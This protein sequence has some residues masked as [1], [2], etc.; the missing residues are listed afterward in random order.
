MQKELERYDAPPEA[1]EAKMKVKRCVDE[2]LFQLDKVLI[3]GAVV[4]CLSF[5]QPKIPT[6]RLAWY[7]AEHQGM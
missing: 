7:L 4:S 1:V 6:M 2:S 3:S 5:M